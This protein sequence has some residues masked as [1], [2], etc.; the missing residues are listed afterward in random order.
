MCGGSTPETPYSSVLLIIYLEYGVQSRE[1]KDV[2]D[3]LVGVQELQ[4]R[5]FAGCTQITADQLADSR[6]AVQVR[7]LLEIQQNVPDARLERAGDRAAY[8][9]R[10]GGHCEPAA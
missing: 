6:C 8:E 7:D 3:I 5:P 4:A 9:P 10:S 2:V 1:M